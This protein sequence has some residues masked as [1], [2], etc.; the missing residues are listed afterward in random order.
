MHAT[1]GSSRA[2]PLLEENINHD[3]QTGQVNSLQKSVS[4]LKH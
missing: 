4:Y 1:N 3:K 2:H